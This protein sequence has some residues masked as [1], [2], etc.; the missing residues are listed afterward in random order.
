MAN[1]MG[2]SF[3]GQAT[4]LKQMFKRLLPKSALIKKAAAGG[5]Y[6]QPGRFSINRFYSDLGRCGILTCVVPELLW[7][8]IF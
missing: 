1:Y 6:R 3:A 8:K 2:F 5:G 4:G 7:K